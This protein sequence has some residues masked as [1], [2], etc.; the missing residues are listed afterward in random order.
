MVSG[1]HHVGTPVPSALATSLHGAIG[2]SGQL[3]LLTGEPG[4]G[5]TTMAR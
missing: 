4:I 3:V 5:K 2:G 1:Q